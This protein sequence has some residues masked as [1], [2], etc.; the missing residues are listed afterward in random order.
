MSVNLITKEAIA[1]ALERLLLE[2]QFSKIPVKD[3]TEACGISRNT[4]YYHF[5]DKYEL[6]NWIVD[7]DMAKN[8]E[9]YD[10][11]MRIPETFVS[12]CAFMYQRKKFYYP[13]M[14]YDG[15]NSLYSHLTNFFFELWMLNI[16]IVYRESGF[17][18]SEY[19]ITVY[20]KM[21]AHALVGL[22]RDWVDSGMH[23]NYRSYFEQVSEIFRLQSEMYAIMSENKQVTKRANAAKDIGGAQVS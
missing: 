7:D 21:N 15:Q 18:L 5:K 4:F 10:N 11:P 9:D 12:M 22:M 16:D 23:D 13:C 6:M 1:S 2:R 3:I 14:Q 8:V 19:E 17:K 20:A